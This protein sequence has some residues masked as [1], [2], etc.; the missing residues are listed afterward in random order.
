MLDKIFGRESKTND[1]I[2]RFLYFI[3]AIAISSLFLVLVNGTESLFSRMM[4]SLFPGIWFGL[5]ANQGRKGASIGRAIILMITYA[6]LIAITFFFLNWVLNQRVP[7]FLKILILF[8]GGIAVSLTLRAY[9]ERAIG[10]SCR[11]S[12]LF[13]L[14]GAI[15]FAITFYLINAI[16]YEGLS[17]PIKRVAAIIILAVWQLVMGF[18]LSL[19]TFE[20]IRDDQYIQELIEDI[21][22]DAE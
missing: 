22:E 4:Y 19:N 16:Y 17:L 20:D 5:A 18:M 14:W 13:G 6:G 11:A 10:V 12:W 9:Y 15:G 7:D 21:G 8:A 2:I 3:I 1:F